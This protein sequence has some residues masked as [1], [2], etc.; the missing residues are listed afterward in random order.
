MTGRDIL[1]ASILFFLAGTIYLFNRRGMESG[2][3]KFIV[4]LDGDP[5]YEGK[6]YEDRTVEITGDRIY[7]LLRVANK[8][9]RVE[10]AGCPKKICVKQ[11]PISRKGQSL[12]CVPQELIITVKGRKEELDAI[13]R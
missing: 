2:P 7:L 6:L 10:K 11:G 4:N 9:V 5:V 8:E 3:D 12:I 1:L 13:T